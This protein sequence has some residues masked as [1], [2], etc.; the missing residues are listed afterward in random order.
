MVPALKDGD[1]ESLINLYIFQSEV[2]E[3]L[4]LL[5]RS[6]KG[7]SITPTFRS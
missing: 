5:R 6:I 7:P 1:G 3:V 4:G 2:S